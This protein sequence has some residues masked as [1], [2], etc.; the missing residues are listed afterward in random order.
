MA[1][2]YNPFTF[3]VQVY[4]QRPIETHSHKTD[5]HTHTY[6]GTH[7]YS[8]DHMNNKQILKATQKKNAHLRKTIGFIFL[9]HHTSFHPFS[10]QEIFSK[11]SFQELLCFAI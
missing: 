6:A 5:T 4:G 11:T 10:C 9:A 7:F 8:A 1:V 2:I 3:H